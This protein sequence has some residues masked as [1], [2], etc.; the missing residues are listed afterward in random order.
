MK[1]AILEDG[2]FSP[3]VQKRTV[4]NSWK[5]DVIGVI[6]TYR[7]QWIGDVH[8]MTEGREVIYLYFG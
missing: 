6:R 8:L 2:G 3:W 4:S 7:K 5:L 1:G